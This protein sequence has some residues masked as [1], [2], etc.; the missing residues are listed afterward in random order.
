MGRI[1]ASVAPASTGDIMNKI[2]SVAIMKIVPLTNMDT[3][4]LRLS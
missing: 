2:T 4:V 1:A 3:F